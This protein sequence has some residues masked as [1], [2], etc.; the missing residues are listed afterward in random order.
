MINKKNKPHGIQLVKFKE[1]ALKSGYPFENNVAEII[2]SIKSD[3]PSITRP[4]TFYATTENGDT[5]IRSVDFMCTFGLDVKSI[6]SWGRGREEKVYLKFLIEAKYSEDKFWFIP[7][8]KTSEQSVVHFP[9]LIP[10]LTKDDFGDDVNI[11]RAEFESV[12]SCPKKWEWASSGRKVK[13]QSRERDSLADYQV[14]VTTAVHDILNKDLNKLGLRT[15]TNTY[16]SKD[17]TIY[18]PI[19]VTNAPLYLLNEGV[20][21]DKVNLSKIE[22]D[23]CKIM[24]VLLVTQPHL[25]HIKN[26]LRELSKNVS[27]VGRNSLRWVSC[28]MTLFP[29]IFTNPHKLKEIMEIFVKRV[30]SIKLL[31]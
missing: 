2:F 14:Q 7:E 13:E 9:H 5:A 25:F 11:Y 15:P 20:T 6:P 23:L 4:I 16:Y 26:I 1:W 27:S 28:D 19:I 31:D 3:P 29:I 18:I 30:K 12:S 21:V 8:V 10:R 22:S 24:D 17:I